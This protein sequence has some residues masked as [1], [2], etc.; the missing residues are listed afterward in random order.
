MIDR[1]EKYTTF[2]IL[3]S[4]LSQIFLGIPYFSISSSDDGT[5]RHTDRRTINLIQLL[6]GNLADLCF[7]ISLNMYKF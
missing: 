4:V 3:Y 1:F 6:N 7:L 2:L 5:N